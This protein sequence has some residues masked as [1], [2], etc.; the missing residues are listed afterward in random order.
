MWDGRPGRPAAQS[1]RAAEPVSPLEEATTIPVVREE[2]RDIPRGRRN[3]KNAAL[4]I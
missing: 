3:R 1:Y 4:H 2:A